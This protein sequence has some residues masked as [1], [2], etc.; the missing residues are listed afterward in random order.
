MGARTAVIDFRYHIVSLVAVFL[1]LALGLF[2]GS[3]SLQSTVTHSL[4]KQADRVTTENQSLE[5]K[6]GQLGQELSA[7]QAFADAVEPYA[8]SDKL[9]DAGIAVVSAPGV[10]DGDRSAL[11]HTLVLAGATVTADVR[12]QSSY[13]D[14]NQ[15]ATLAQLASQ[16]AG[17]H[18][19]PTGDGA[20]QAG[21]ELARA[22]VTRP[23]ARITS[24]RRI[25][26]ILST[27]TDAKM[28]SVSGNAPVRPAD[29]VVVLVP[30]GSAPDGS[31]SAVQQDNDLIGL[32]RALRRGSSGLVVA[33]PTL[34]SGANNGVIAVIRADSSLTKTISTV[35]ADDT[36]VGRVAT[37]LA[38]SAAPS[39][40][41]G[42]YGSTQK[43]PLP[44]TSPVP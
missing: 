29:L 6:N 14:P 39:G 13:L 16:L 44:T 17:T 31:A 12:L 4:Q 33:A 20:T 2:L 21:T 23:G 43:A 36:S 1:A 35:D 28:I 3:T 40:T 10:D 24:T 25:E 18:P 22:L 15:D 27:L 34:Q 41:T 9:V 7:S 30:V 42:R 8:V 32:A 38:L 37:V 19:L 26:L 5:G 11:I